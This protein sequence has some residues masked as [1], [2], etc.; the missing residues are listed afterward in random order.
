MSWDI[1]II[2]GMYSSEAHYY[3]PTVSSESQYENF[4][5]VKICRI[6]K[7]LKAQGVSGAAAQVSTFLLQLSSLNYR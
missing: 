5:F 3:S 4:D 7:A 1:K 6:S 2:T